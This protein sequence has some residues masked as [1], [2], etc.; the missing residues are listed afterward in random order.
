M[1]TEGRSRSSRCNIQLEFGGKTFHCRARWQQQ[2][3][4]N[5][6]HQGV[7]FGRFFCSFL[8]FA[9]SSS[10]IL[11]HSVHQTSH[12]SA[13][14]SSVSCFAVLYVLHSNRFFLG[15]AHS[16]TALPSSY[17]HSLLFTRSSSFIHFNAPHPSALQS[18]YS[19]L[20]LGDSSG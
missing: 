18:V 17:V 20:Q 1:Y 19:L 13:A 10:C 15:F 16:L 2:H 8:R 11:V 4:G 14:S 5:C 7:L 9:F 6:R 3:P 12:A